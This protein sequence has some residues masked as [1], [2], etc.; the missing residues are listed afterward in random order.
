MFYKFIKSLR[1]PSLYPLRA[2][3]VAGVFFT[4]CAIPFAPWSTLIY[5]GPTVG[6]ILFCS[7]KLR[8]FIYKY[9]G[10]QPVNPYQGEAHNK[11]GDAGFSYKGYAESFFHLPSWRHPLVFGRAMRHETKYRA[12]RE[13]A[14]DRNTLSNN[15]NSRYR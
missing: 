1:T 12:R 14:E 15:R 9:A 5:V 7:L 4:V 8:N 11:G 3:I 6:S 10:R 13:A 2:S